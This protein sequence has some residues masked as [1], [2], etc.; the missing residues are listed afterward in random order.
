[1]QKTIYPN[2]NGVPIIAVMGPSG[3]GKSTMLK[4][5][6][7]NPVASSMKIEGTSA[8]Q[9]TLIPT[10]FYIKQEL[11]QN[12]D[13]EYDTQ[14]KLRVT[15]RT[16]LVES[17]QEI[18]TEGNN[19]SRE[20]CLDEN[21]VFIALQYGI[22]DFVN[23]SSS[24]GISVDKIK[25]YIESGA[26]FAFICAAV[27]GAVR[28][29]YL[30]DDV[31]FK[32]V[33]D[34]CALSL[35]DA[36]D[37]DKFN[38]TIAAIN[39]DIE[40]KRV[41]KGVLKDQL[42]VAWGEERKNTNSSVCKLINFVDNKVLN[43]FYKLIPCDMIQDLLK[44][45][46]ECFTVAL[47][48]SNKNDKKVLGELVDPYALFSL[49]IEK[50]EIACAM[51]KGFRN[52][53]RIQY[54]QKNWIHDQLPFRLIIT[55]TVGLTQDTEADEYD[56]S[57]RLNA[58]LNTGCHGILVMMPPMKDGQERTMFRAY[59]TQ[60]DEGRRIRRNAI[61]IYLGIARIDEEITPS[62]EFEE[63]EDAYHQEMK[64]KRDTLF[65][66]KEAWKTQIKAKDARYITNSPKKIKAYLD[67]LKEIDPELAEW[68]ARDMSID[69]I[70]RYLFDITKEMQK[71]MFPNNTPIFYHV[72]QAAK[73][74]TI[75]LKL[76]NPNDVK[77]VANSLS[78][79]SDKYCISQWLHWNTAYA[80]Y[81]ATL[82]GRRFLSK[83]VQNGRISIYIK[84]DVNNAI[85]PFQNSWQDNTEWDRNV[86]EQVDISAVD[87]I[88]SS[89][90]S[91]LERVSVG[92]NTA[93]SHV[94]D[95][96]YRLFRSNFTGDFM[97]RFWRVIDR[98]ICRLSCEGDVRNDAS[99]AFQHGRLEH[100]ASGGVEEML[101]YYRCLYNSA[102]L[103]DTVA[104]IMNE[105]F[106]KEFNSFFFPLYD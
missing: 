12:Q 68:F 57:R 89:S 62:V 45:G 82:E 7:S 65:K 93:I 18:P 87:L 22:I 97:W 13:I 101:H 88:N 35:V 1:M 58:A 48:I 36:I 41:R 79:Y 75:K 26:Y 47:D 49:I 15:L 40:K 103:A 27:N 30:K 38:S 23:N 20:L 77:D 60:T 91:L 53:L 106:T 54:E 37:I 84:G 104:E 59:S 80:F 50:Y 81:N 55:D 71:R 52:M 19:I 94:K 39:T 90:K 78:A 105:E 51:S 100:D 85:M 98:V 2:T 32:E 66:R 99:A 73:E 17:Q 9:T 31:E 29:S 56:V 102:N 74:G 33:V 3:V 25:K 24:T 6:I 10:Q 83:A 64:E 5:L 67:D 11:G 63:D 96:L 8:A 34:R 69:A 44:L 21:A 61:N 14:L 70:Y 42:C 43:L 28:F 92:D 72:N 76:V 95:G 16:T 46:H 4:K 86:E